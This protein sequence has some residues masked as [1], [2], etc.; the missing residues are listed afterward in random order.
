MFVGMILEMLGV[1]VIL[2]MLTL[3]TSNGVSENPLLTRFK[4]SIP[5]DSIGPVIA[6]VLISLFLIKNLFLTFQAW[7]QN[8]FI[9]GVQESL[10]QRLLRQ[11]ITLPYNFHLRRNSAQLIR[12]TSSE[13]TQY[14]YNVITPLMGLFTEIVIMAGL[15]GLLLFIEPIGT[16]ISGTVLC[17]VGFGYHF[18]THRKSIAL[19]E[20]RMLHEGLRI[21][22]IQQALGGIKE[23]KLMGCEDALLT[24]YQ[25]HNKLSAHASRIHG[26]LIQL[27]RLAL[28]VVGI[29]AFGILIWVMSIQGKDFAAII[30]TLGLV[31]A[32]AFR[33]IPSA[34]RILSAINSLRY[35][36]A[37]VDTLSTEL[38]GLSAE[39]DSAH[40]DSG[41]AGFQFKDK[42][43]VSGLT[44]SYEETNEPV[45]SDV[46]FQIPKNTS[47]GIVGESG[48]GKSTLVDIML[49]LLAPQSGRV[50]VDG[51]D[52]NGG[53]RSWQSHIGYVPQSIYLSDQ[54][55]RRNVAF[56]LT[57]DQIDDE[58]VMEV[59]KA[60]HLNDLIES[61]PEKLETVIGERGVRL[62][63]G[64]RQRIGIARALYRNPKVLVFDEAT[65]ALD[66]ESEERVMEAI[67]DLQGSRTVV[68]VAHRLSTIEH[69]DH[70]I[71]LEK[72]R[73]IQ[74]G[75]VS[76]ALL[77]KT[78]H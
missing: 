58:R 41:T 7:I 13:V 70:L 57:D 53:M 9:F 52:I 40:K 6:I 12:N 63:G 77:T 16:L 21:Q 2:P 72:G 76:E 71:R 30:P 37:I 1:G 64:Q 62:S 19:G 48:S 38:E 17:G 32:A 67:R 47:V 65:S 4:E 59:L 42:I 20:S 35:G 44:F 61:L 18:L 75:P 43:E 8:R 36:K 66:N 10:S 5:G 55:L 50:L 25:V 69:C 73:I 60:S 51:E 14:V 34:N 39:K 15:L 29:T 56:G 23:V 45:L 33:L 27:P 31:A 74:S 68:I 3:L 22:N 46:S 26:V 54:S 11:Y 24:D 78:V 28:E 49:G